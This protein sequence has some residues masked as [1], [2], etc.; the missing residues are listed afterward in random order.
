MRFCLKTTKKTHFC[1]W[2]HWVTC[3]FI[4]MNMGTVVYF[5]STLHSYHA[6]L[7]TN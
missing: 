5:K 6:A 7:N 2:L 1:V 3:S 4:A